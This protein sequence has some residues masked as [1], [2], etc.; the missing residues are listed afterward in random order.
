[1]STLLKILSKSLPQIF[2]NFSFKSKPAASESF[3]SSKIKFK[4]FLDKN[5]KV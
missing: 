3:L 5:I 2:Q 4:I 1:M